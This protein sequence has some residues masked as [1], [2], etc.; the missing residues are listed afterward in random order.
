MEVEE[1]KKRL[2]EAKQR[3]QKEKE[4]R[5]EAEQREQKE[6]KERQ[7]AEEE[8]QK[9]KKVRQKAEEERQKAQE[10]LQKEKEETRKTTLTEYLS[11]CHECL[12]KSISIQ[13]DES[14]STQGDPSN[15]DG[16]LRPDRLQP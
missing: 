11:L 16:K 15:A 13:T 7:K 2:E 10:E 8:R 4:E 14:L 6:K 12:S 9:E 3:E 1:L 5:Q